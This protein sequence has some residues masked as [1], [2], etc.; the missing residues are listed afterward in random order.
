MDQSNSAYVLT[1]ISKKFQFYIHLSFLIIITD[2]FWNDALIGFIEK[3]DGEYGAIIGHGYEYRWADEIHI[4][5]YRCRHDPRCCVF[6]Y[7]RE[8]SMCTL[9]K[10]CKPNGY[11]VLD[12]VLYQKSKHISHIKVHI[13]FRIFRTKS[14]N[15]IILLHSII[16]IGMYLFFYF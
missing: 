4:C 6:E 10:E 3:Y 16:N 2:P 9:H 15:F 8:S 1:Y 11:P 5:A 14:S 12:T 13:P 7:S